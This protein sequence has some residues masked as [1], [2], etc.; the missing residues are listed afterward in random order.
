MSDNIVPFP[1]GKR[2]APPQSLNEI[3]S[4]VDEIRAEHMPMITENIM[5]IVMYRLHEEGFDIT[6]KACLIPMAYMNECLKSAMLAS[7]GKDHKLQS[8]AISYYNSEVE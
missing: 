4:S 2:N 7:I 8:A 1:K 6:K 5:E 3:L